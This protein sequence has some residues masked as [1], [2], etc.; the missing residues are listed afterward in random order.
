MQKVAIEAGRSTFQLLTMN[1]MMSFRRMTLE[2]ADNFD[3]VMRE[4]GAAEEASEAVA[5]ARAAIGAAR[6]NDARHAAIVKLLQELDF[7]QQRK[8]L[9]T[10]RRLAP[11]PSFPELE[12]I[13]A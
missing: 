12:K 6:G 7:G 8:V 9:E 3:A 4:S 1:P 2:I 13:G 10:N 5:T 11:K